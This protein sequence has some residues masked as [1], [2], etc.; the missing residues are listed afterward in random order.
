MESA[1][2]RDEN[3]PKGGG[4]RRVEGE[5][6]QNFKESVGFGGERLER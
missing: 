1:E 5:S 3:R 6:C 2:E 4:E